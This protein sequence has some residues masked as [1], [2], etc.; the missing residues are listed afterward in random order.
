[1][2]LPGIRLADDL[3]VTDDLEKAV[4]DV[5]LVVVAVPSHAVRGI[6]AGLRSARLRGVPIVS[7]AKGIENES[8][9]LMREVMMDVLGG[10]IEKRLAVLSGPSFA[11]EV[12]LGLPTAVVVASSCPELAAAAQQRFAGERLRVYTS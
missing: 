5:S 8:L 4:S 9:M 6:A 11:R 1:R 12:A 2:Y 7:A 10:A 3:E